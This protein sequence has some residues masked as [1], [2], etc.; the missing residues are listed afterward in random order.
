MADAR[1]SPAPTP[2]G[3][4]PTVASAELWITELTANDAIS[5]DVGSAF[6]NGRN[7][8]RSV[9]REIPIPARSITT[10]TAMRAR[11]RAK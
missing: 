2:R 7:A 5:I 4:L 10:N 6:R 11:S 1:K 8:T 3:A 9:A